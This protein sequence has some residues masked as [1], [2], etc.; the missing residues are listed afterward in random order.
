MAS[1]PPA[2]TDGVGER[3]RA[4]KGRTKLTQRFI[5]VVMSYG[6]SLVFRKLKTKPIKYTQGAGSVPPIPL[7]LAQIMEECRHGHTITGKSQG[8]GFHNPIHLQ[9]MLRQSPFLLMVSASR[10]RK[11]AG[12]FHEANDV[13]YLGSLCSTEYGDDPGLDGH[14]GWS[15]PEKGANQFLGAY[16]STYSSRTS[17][18]G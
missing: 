7:N 12:R 16:P 13:L 15:V 11:I 18:S 9:A 2:G 1:L 3:E 8:C 4:T 14:G 6:E 10:L 17:L 5:V